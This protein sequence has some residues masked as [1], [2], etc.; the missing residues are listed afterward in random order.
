M[1]NIRD[2]AV[3]LVKGKYFLRIVVVLFAIQA[4]F[5][6]FSIKFG[7]PPDEAYHYS[8][9]KYYSNQS[10]IE[11]PVISGQSPKS[12]P[13]IRTLNR[14]ASYLYHYLSSFSLRIIRNFSE[15][16][17]MQVL[18]LRLQSVA[19]ALLTI[20]FL[21]KCLNEISN[22]EVLKNLSIT[23][24]AFT[25]MFV[26]IS[27]SINYDNLANLLFSVFLLYS[28]RYVKKRQ[29]QDFLM[30][31]IFG[32]Y[33]CLTKYTFMPTVGL[34]LLITGYIFI[35]KYLESSIKADLKKHLKL[36]IS[37]ILMIFFA[38]TG[39]VMAIERFGLNVIKYGNVQ[40]S[41][42]KLFTREECVTNALYARNY[43]QKDIFN[44]VNKTSFINN[45]N[46]FTHTGMWSYS[47]YNNLFFYLGHKK[48]MS[49]TTSE[50][51]AAASTIAFLCTLF[52]PRRRLFSLLHQYYLYSIVLAYIATL[53][54]FNALTLLNYGKRFA[55]Q[56]RYL[57]PVI[58]FVFYIVGLI[59]LRASQKLPENKKNI[60][61]MSWIIIAILLTVSHFPAIT[62]IRG[63]NSDWY[64]TSYTNLIN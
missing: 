14:S 56:G 3:K 19:L 5:F 36:S 18:L 57:I 11:G 13:E 1:K 29:P 28:I 35:R 42:I 30:S 61:L 23:A 63:V 58:V 41:C 50:L 20:V 2:K 25:G 64:S 12:I 44:R 16:V 45:E 43:N 60:F 27:S 22:N 17:E 49:T 21:K 33:T 6:S 10:I 31:Y 51:I 39:T 46:P 34:G 55:Y 48:I 7:V 38:F 59:I 24:L 4:I 26:W 15:N 32:L 53:Y 8:A 9:I 52:L 54:L 47:M 62:F 37:T 40:P